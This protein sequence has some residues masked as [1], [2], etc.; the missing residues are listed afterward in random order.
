M[1]QMR[2]HSRSAL[3]L[4]VLLCL[5]V[6]SAA[7]AASPASV[8]VRVE[9]LTEAKV[10]PT[11]VTT[12]TTPV[13][14]DDNSADSCSGTSALGALELATAGNWS[15]PWEAKFNQYSI[16]SIAGETHEFEEGAPANYFWSFWLNNK[17]S[18][19][20]AC[21]AE[22]QPGDQVLFFPSCFGSACPTP[23]PTPLAIEAPA[24]ANTGETVTVTVKQYNASGEASPAVGADVG[25]GGTGAIAD[26]QGHATL[27]F[28]G[29]ATYTL[30]AS[31]GA[32]R[33][34]G[35]RTEATIC[36][37]EG[38][39]GTCGTPLVNKGDLPA[40]PGSSVPHVTEPSALRAA[41]GGARDGHVYSRRK[42][43]RVLS[44]KVTSKSSVTSISIRLRRSYRHRCWAYNGALERFV[45]ARCGRGAF[46]KVR[47][48]GSSFSYLLP[49]RLARGRYVF[50]IEASDTA[51]EHTAL[52]RGTSSVVFYVR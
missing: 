12:T 36:V 32:E 5:L 24:S 9:G 37:H 15:G 21:E 3:L 31:A 29:D 47:S 30:R 34:P 44:G 25:G 50:D 20:G 27:K 39:D 7:V 23:E 10:L 19:V 51:G 52:H 8:S 46:F 28:F 13:V 48:G 43:P 2:I 35:I 1:S 17:F 26:A 49:S 42:A 4:G 14:K 45:K 18:E 22:L 16:A 33:P 38:N 41:A 40:P 11:L 6:P